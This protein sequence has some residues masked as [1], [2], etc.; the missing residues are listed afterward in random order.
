[1]QHKQFNF[2]LAGTNLA[3]VAWA[4]LAVAPAFGGT[5][6]QPSRP[7]PLLDG[8]PTDPCAAGADYA[9]GIDVNG[10]PVIPADIA[11]RRVPLPDAVAIPLTTGQATG[12]GRN[13]SSSDRRGRSPVARSAQKD[14][15]QRD[16]TYVS[17]DGRALDP[18]LNPP[19]C[20]SVHE[21]RMPRN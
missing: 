16:S 8:G 15:T 13:H 3:L 5:I 2:V 10:K 21:P 19:L 17:L 18:L 7:D 12:Q 1:M 6:V 20:G 4:F 11:P 14:G 9:A